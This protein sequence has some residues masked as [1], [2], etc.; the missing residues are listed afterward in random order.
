MSVA[1]VSSEEF[2]H[3]GARSMLDLAFIAV[4]LAFFGLCALY[5]AA[6]ERL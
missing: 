5:A 2:D 6:C 4:T 1:I 3:S